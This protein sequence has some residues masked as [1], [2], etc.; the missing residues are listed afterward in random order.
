[1][2]FLFLVSLWRRHVNSRA[3]LD[4]LLKS[5]YV[6][7]PVGLEPTT[8]CLKGNCST[9]LSYGRIY[10]QKYNINSTKINYVR[11]NPAP[12]F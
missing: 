11:E 4:V 6:V 3:P 2:R 7:R 9:K 10:K 5:F 8:V 1:M 12:L